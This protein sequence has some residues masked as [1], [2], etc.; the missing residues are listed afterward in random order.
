MLKSLF[1][2][3]FL[4]FLALAALIFYLSVYGIETNKFNNIVNE[5]FQKIN[6]N[7]NLLLS[8]VYLKLN[9]RKLLINIEVNK[10]E[11]II[12]NSKL[13]LSKIKASVNIFKLIKK[14]NS[15]DQL[16]I[17]LEENKIKDLASF[18]NEYDFNLA[19][20]I[21]FNQI[22]DGIAKI[23]IKINLN[24]NDRSKIDYKLNGYVKNGK[25]NFLNKHK[26]SNINF[27][28]KFGNKKTQLNDLK[29]NY[30]N[31][32]FLSNNIIIE[33]SKNFY[34]KGD[35]ENIKGNILP[36]AI[37][38]Y[39]DKN[40]NFFDEK[41]TNIYSKNN[42]SFTIK[43]NKLQNLKLNSKINYDKL[44][45]NPEYTEL[46]YLEN[47]VIESN[48]NNNILNL[49]LNSQFK[50]F[51]DDYNSELKNN[52]KVRIKRKNKKTKLLIEFDNNENIIETKELTKFFDQLKDLNLSKKLKI[53]SNNK[54]DL[55][56]DKNNNF[57]INKIDTSLKVDK[58]KV[59]L[60][61]PNLKKFF[62]EF[63]NNINF[64]NNNFKIKLVNKKISISSNH[65][66]FF[67]NK[68]NKDKIN[69]N[70]VKTKDNI[71]IIANW[72]LDNQNINISELNFTKAKK[73]FANI[74]TNFNIN[75]KKFL[76]NDFNFNNKNGYIKINNLKFDKNYKIQNIEFAEL[77]LINKKSM[78]IQV[79][80]TK[81]NSD[82]FISGN[83]FDASS[84]IKNFI[85]NQNQTSKIKLFSNLNSKINIK[86]EKILIDKDSYF[87]NFDGNIRFKKNNIYFSDINSLI[88]NKHKFKF[89]LL[90]DKNNQKITNLFIENPES[91]IKNYDFIKGFKEG[92]L[93]YESVKINNKSR[94]KLNIYNFKIREVPILAKLLTLA[95]LQGIADLLTGE[96]IRFDEF[97]M[98][99]ITTK[100]KTEIKEMFALGPAISILME[101][102]IV[103][104]EVTSLR[105][106]LVPATTINKSISKIPLLGDILVGKKVGEGVF[107]VSFKIKGAP[108]KLKT[109][110]NPIKT[111]TPRFITRTLE[112]ISN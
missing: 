108:K 68:K 15:I 57:K 81:K 31:L 50:F 25:I 80:L 13:N 34:V 88:N 3:L 105:G 37:T 14:Q 35:L 79:S 43:D 77:N 22:D 83:F 45:L 106:T 23:T 107:G 110:V 49:S 40:F 18:L 64:Y 53:S 112:K 71:N 111:L 74:K 39:L 7:L 16:E 99:Y 100:N 47:G 10:S 103:K 2:F 62:P 82:Y 95:S 19:R 42:F 9:I 30:S 17:N 6:P 84:Q 12:D 46:F 24:D 86:F 65:E 93:V 85:K 5:K 21:L 98:D 33:K 26:I 73:E 8:D 90:T 91:F 1:K 66:Y 89:N 11:V 27:K 72:I 104:N 52:L 94:S 70:L 69:L 41:Y 55:E 29:F 87:N 54:I 76:I 51:N 28:F 97:E 67:E 56:I 78:P 60:D 4:I 63:K 36:K 32:N 109:T 75:N 20:F 101:G 59:F 96:G 58:F 61:N 102:Y 38:K 48:Y 44:I 92:K